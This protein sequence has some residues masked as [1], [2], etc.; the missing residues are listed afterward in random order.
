MAWVPT[1]STLEHWR[2][3]QRQ[4]QG[5]LLPTGRSAHPLAVASLQLRLT[6]LLRWAFVQATLAANREGGFN[7]AAS[8]YS[9]FQEGLLLPPPGRLH[10]LQ[11]GQVAAAA[12]DT[13][14][15][16][17][18]PAQLPGSNHG[19]LAAGPEQLQEQ[20]DDVVVVMPLLSAALELK[21]ARVLREVVAVPASEAP[22]TWHG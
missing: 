17:R 19:M 5:G 3:Q 11:H 2:R 13:L 9:R 18:L 12:G 20:Q 21:F 8:G 6:G 1:T 16:Q 14:D 22:V 4:Q 7:S 15:F 10:S